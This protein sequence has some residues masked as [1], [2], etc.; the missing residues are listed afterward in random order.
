MSFK[1]LFRKQLGRLKLPGGKGVKIAGALSGAAPF[2]FDPEVLG[3]RGSAKDL[4]KS[5]D[6]A[7]ADKAGEARE[8]EAQRQI[9]ERAAAD[10][11]QREGAR[12]LQEEEEQRRRLREAST[13]GFAST[14]LS[15]GAGTSGYG[16]AGRRLYGS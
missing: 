6:E 9:E 15:G 11:V 8:A 14:V 3:A 5:V 7:K 2:M 1:K 10:E 16:A 13:G 4:G 12:R